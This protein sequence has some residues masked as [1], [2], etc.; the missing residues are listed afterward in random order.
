MDLWTSCP[1]IQAV[2]TLKRERERERPIKRTHPNT[3]NKN[4]IF[5]IFYYKD[6]N[7]IIVI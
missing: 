2:I 6:K 7:I 3:G 1:H 5:F 4:K